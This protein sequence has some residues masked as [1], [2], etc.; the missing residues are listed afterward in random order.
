MIYFLQ[1]V[2]I[3]S[4]IFGWY[5]LIGSQLLIETRLMV[6]ALYLLIGVTASTDAAI[7]WRLRR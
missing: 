4:W 1:A 3:F 2:A 6:G 5:L 7:L